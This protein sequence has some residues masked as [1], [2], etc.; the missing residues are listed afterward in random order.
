MRKAGVCKTLKVV[1]KSRDLILGRLKKNQT[2]RC[3]AENQPDELFHQADIRE[4][5]IR[6]DFGA[7]YK[8]RIIRC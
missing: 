1:C 3:F 5:A 7:N 6:Q 2:P 4:A 8:S